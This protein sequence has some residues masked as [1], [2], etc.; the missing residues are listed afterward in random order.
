MIAA[1]FDETGERC[2]PL[3]FNHAKHIYFD[4]QADRFFLSVFLYH[5]AISQLCGKSAAQFGGG[6][7]QAELSDG[8]APL[9]RTLSVAV[10]I[11]ALR[12]LKIQRRQAVGDILGFTEAEL[13][14]GELDPQLRQGLATVAKGRFTVIGQPRDKLCHMCDLPFKALF[15]MPT[16]AILGELSQLCG[17][18]SLGRL[19]EIIAAWFGLG[20]NDI[21]YIFH[22]CFGFCK[23]C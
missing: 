19:G 14:L 13:Y 5:F 7:G 11:A 20:G 6:Y 23:V 9:G 15:H 18:V 12:Y 2:P 17:I 16:F 10:K 3:H 22:Y 4:E 21:T 1:N 8:L